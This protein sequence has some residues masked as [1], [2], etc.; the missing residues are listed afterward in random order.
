MAG[1]QVESADSLSSQLSRRIAISSRLSKDLGAAV[2]DPDSEVYN[3][4]RGRTHGLGFPMYFG[5][6]S[7]V[8]GG[9]TAA[10]VA[11]WSEMGCGNRCLDIL[12]AR[13][14]Y[15]SL[16][17]PLA[18]VLLLTLHML[19][20]FCP[21]HLPH[22]RMI[23]WEGDR[24]LGRSIF[25]IAV[26]SLLGSLFLLAHSYPTV[27]LVVSIFLCPFAVLF[28]RWFIRPQDIYVLECQSPSL[29]SL[30]LSR[31][32]STGSNA[33]LPPP[34]ALGAEEDEQ[35]P[36]GRTFTEESEARRE[37][38]AL[39]E[40]AEFERRMAKL[41]KITGD[42]QDQRDFYLAAAG[43]FA[44]AG[45]L[46]FA[47][48]AAWALQAGGMSH[49]ERGLNNMEKELFFIRWAAPIGI[50]TANLMFASLMFLRVALHQT[51]LGAHEV[52]TRLVVES[53]HCA[54]GTDIMKHRLEAFVKAQEAI[55]MTGGPNK[56][57]RDKVQEYLL[58]QITSL[59]KLAAIIKV[60]NVILVLCL[61][62]LFITF[63]FA[64][65][66]SY[67]AE[68]TQGFM[69]AL[70]LTGLVYTLMAFGRLWAQL[71]VWLQDLAMWKSAAAAAGK[72]WAQS[73]ACTL[74]FP[75]APWV[76]V[77]DVLKQCIRRWRRIQRIPPDQIHW[78]LGI[79]INAVA[80]GLQTW[81]WVLVMQW[82]YL[83]GWLL[84]LNKV[85]PIF[86]NLLLAWV[87]ATISDLPFELIC[88][89][90][91]AMG[92]FLFM[93]PPVPGPPI[94]LFGG[95]VITDKCPLGFW[96][97][98]LICITLC[99][100]LKLTACAIQQKLI[101]GYLSHKLWVKQACGVHTPLMRAIE[102]V[103]KKPGLSFGKVMI[104]CGGPDWPT[105][106]LAGILGISLFQCELGTCPIIVSVAP[107]ALSGSFYL[108][109]SGWGEVWSRM[110]NLMFMLTGVVSIGFWVGMG[111]AIQDEFDKSH[112]IITMP[113]EEFVDLEWLDYSVAYISK[114]C[115][116][117]W[118]DVPRWVMVPC[119][120][121]SV[122]LI[123]IGHLFLWR[124]QAC[125]G[126]FRVGD[127][128]GTLELYGEAGLLKP[129][130][131]LGLAIA[132]VS[133][134]GLP[135]FKCWHR[136]KSRILAADAVQYMAA[137]EKEWKA[138]RVAEAQEA[139]RRHNELYRMSDKEVL[140][141]VSA[142][143]AEN[144]FR[145]LHQSVTRLP[146]KLSNVI[147]TPRTL[148]SSPRTPRTGSFD[149]TS[150]DTDFRPFQAS[151]PALGATEVGAG[152]NHG[153]LT[154]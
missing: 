106:V 154:L 78:S 62:V 90:T 71:K 112:H 105:S 129:L 3:T 27:P 77:V 42:S 5:L 84:I 50:G 11:L 15:V 24:V 104:L 14:G 23:L 143:Q 83:W 34:G 124:A 79:R 120:L 69:G 91:F 118:S 70:S 55:D 60:F 109:R 61:G 114:Q 65:A 56:L 87:S 94:Y 126:V 35:P 85:M 21:P 63:Q 150:G 149:P 46:C 92:M 135:L 13:Q 113:R 134:A 151:R 8:V 102:R 93:L 123:C 117:R 47:S 40:Q 72:P 28:L 86:L 101:G 115:R 130:G 103:I 29:S 97:G 2:G 136:R 140:Q 89:A 145:R 148:N 125:F 10:S 98:A 12:R 116:V 107:L 49:L 100:I 33:S 108:R 121:G 16:F 38:A 64:A 66:D 128:I 53:T 138:K 137:I 20:F 147:S 26:V 76:L 81:D 119:M 18:V 36:L 1:P 131:A 44:V 122:A 45:L 127:D 99:F 133:T 6:I 19:D 7:L 43:A 142:R 153:V 88:A 74:L 144:W 9:F 95:F 17:A 25:A 73:L 30:T 132:V 31:S 68:F 141:N 54:L 37:E 139:L 41:R 52:R 110:G 80:R 32:G 58:Q 152:G 146:N 39:A 59:R 67:V 82:C 4:D 75:F 111:W 22:R 57:M 48:F 51:Y 96:W